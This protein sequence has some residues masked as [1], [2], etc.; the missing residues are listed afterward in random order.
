[1]IK[2]VIIINTIAF[3]SV[4]INCN[5]RKCQ[6]L[7]FDEYMDVIYIFF[8]AFFLDVS[9]V[10]TC[11]IIRI[12]FVL[13]FYDHNNELAFRCSMEFRMSFNGLR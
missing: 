7:D 1:M 4:K 8:F 11:L 9:H 3:M 2:N 5:N 12:M 10:I 13:F 6:L